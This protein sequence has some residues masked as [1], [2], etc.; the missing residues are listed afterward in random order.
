MEII[1]N[2]QK[3]WPYCK[4]CGCRLN[5]SGTLVQHWY[6]DIEHVS[7]VE[8]IVRTDARGC[9]CSRVVDFW[10]ACNGELD[11]LAMAQ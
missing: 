5:I 6:G 2:G 11:H 4:E 7:P 3:V 10:I 8:M 1:R 9:H